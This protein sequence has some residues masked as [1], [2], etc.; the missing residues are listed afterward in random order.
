MDNTVVETTIECLCDFFMEVKKISDEWDRQS[1]GNCDIW[2]RGVADKDYQLVPGLVWSGLEQYED[3]LVIDFQNLYLP[4]YNERLRSHWELY[5]LMQHYGLKTRMLDW[6]RSAQMGL[7]FALYDKKSEWTD[8]PIACRCKD[9]AVWVMDPVAL[10]RNTQTEDYIYT[11]GLGGT[12]VDSYL[13]A[14]LKPQRLRDYPIPSKPI[15][16]EAPLVNPRIVAQSGVFTVHGKDV[17]P[18]SEIMKPENGP[19]LYKIVIPSNRKGYILEELRAIGLTE[20]A[21]FKDL[22]TLCKELNRMYGNA[23]RTARER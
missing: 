5:C 11:V 9:A 12:M 19:R 15:A 18:I 14:P 20:Y 10:N 23:V 1:P 4:S 2:Y 17:R 16:I 7:F 22:D 21:V 3:S 13:P 6:T 8:E